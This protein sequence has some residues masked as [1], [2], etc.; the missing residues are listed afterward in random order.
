M[1]GRAFAAAVLIVALSS[2]P[3]S[4]LTPSGTRDGRNY[5]GQIAI[6]QSGQRVRIGRELSSGYFSIGH[7]GVIEG[8]GKRVAVKIWNPKYKEHLKNQPTYAHDDRLLRALSAANPT[9]VRSYGLGKIQGTGE[10]I[11]ATEM[12]DGA[13]F[14]VNQAARG[15][16]KSARIT[17]RVLGAIGAGHKLGFG[18]HDLNMG[19][20]IMNNERSQSVR[21]FDVGGVREKINAQ[22][23]ASDVKKA[24]ELFLQLLLPANKRNR[25]IPERLALIPQPPLRELLTRAVNG[26]FATTEQLT[27]ALQPFTRW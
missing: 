14:R 21:L 27:A 16:G 9:W 1:N 4:A 8:T 25:P 24:G 23:I 2:A 10:A 22:V 7:E 18:S 20:E 19:N 12:A 17:T 3:A 6:L 15:V 26:R 11:L 13:L 5:V